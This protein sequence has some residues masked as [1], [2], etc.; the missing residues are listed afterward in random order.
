M[1]ENDHSYLRSDDAH[2]EGLACFLVLTQ[3]LRIM[4]NRDPDFVRE[5][6]SIV[7]PKSRPLSPI[8]KVAYGRI[9]GLTNLVQGQ[10][11]G[12]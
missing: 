12:E 10:P 4:K 8:E 6:L 1:S 2:G 9:D 5:V 3:M 11:G 7:P